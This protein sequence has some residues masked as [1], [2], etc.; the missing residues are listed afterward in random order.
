MSEYVAFLTIL[1]VSFILNYFLHKVPILKDRKKSLIHKSFTDSR[2]K[3]PFSGGIL[4]LIYLVIFLPSEYNL[5]KIFCFIIFLIGFFSDLEIFKSPNLRFFVQ[6]F[7]IIIFVILTGTFIDSVKISFI[8][9]ILKNFIFKVFFVTFCFMILINGSNFID[10][11]NTL[12]IGYYVLILFFLQN[13]DLN[14]NDQILSVNIS[15]LIL[16]LLIPLFILNF[17]NLLYLGDNG[18]YL[19]SFIVGFLL[20]NIE[21]N[22]ASISPYYI[23]NLLWYPAFENLFSIL[24]KLKNKTS[25]L[26]PDNL[27][28]HQLIFL[29]LKRNI[30]NNRITNTLTGCAINIYNFIIFYMATQDYSNT[31]YQL[32]L[33]FISI[34][35]YSA[36]Y[37]VLKKDLKNDCIK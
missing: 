30:K 36:A 17:F 35:I 18:A 12:A 3:P 10:G 26:E 13:I 8:D 19:I 28:L 16:F 11:V 4:L 21:K 24:R 5:L 7:T 34:F 23:V 31:K 33:I 37:V 20:I 15:K 32:T 22:N 6:L 25:V 14:L 27:H 2:S 9:L 29:F 1:L